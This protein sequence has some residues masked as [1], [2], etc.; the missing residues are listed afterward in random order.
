[1]VHLDA[2]GT[3]CVILYCRCR[4]VVNGGIS[5]VNTTLSMKDYF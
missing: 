1:M 3:D 5:P 2:L 4:K